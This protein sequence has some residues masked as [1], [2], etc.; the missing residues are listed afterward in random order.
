[1]NYI[2]SVIEKIKNETFKRIVLPESEDERVIE[3]ANKACKFCDIYLIGDESLRD[4][5]DSSITILNPKTYGRLNEMCDTFYELRK[6]KGLSKD[7]AYDL[8]TNNSRYFAT[9][10]VY[11]GICDGEVTGANHTSADTYR[12]A[13]Q[14][15]KPK[16]GKASAFMLLEFPNKELGNNG[17]VL[18]ADTGLN[19]NPDSETLADIAF[20][21]SVT[22]ERLVG[23]QS[24][25]GM[26]S[27]STNGSSKHEDVEKVVNALN[28]VKSK[29][30]SLLIDGEMQFD[31][32]ID[33]DVAK[34]KMPDSIIAGHVNTFIFPD[35]DAGNIGYKIAQRLGGANAYG[36]LT[37]G[38]E[39]PIN[40]LSRGCTAED[41][42]GVIAITCLQVK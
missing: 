28:I 41:I 13:F 11:L 4:K 16:S 8:V 15:C 29:H 37:Q 33:I 22:Y 7:E 35:L 5:V 19:Q 42:V 1:M 38:L 21:S 24:M 39:K 20:D 40:D 23:G 6:E 14:I 2:D 31:T 9:M 3:A 12:S 30:P 27:H 18:F 36:P 10:L 25:V 17:V 32:A 34:K 26:L